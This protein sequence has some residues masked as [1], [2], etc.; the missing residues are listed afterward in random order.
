M[1]EY[2]TYNNKAYRFM[3]FDGFEN[4]L[5]FKKLRFARADQFND[6]LDNSPF[7]MPVEWDEF[8]KKGDEFVKG[9]SKTI[10]SSYFK[11]MYICCFS[12]EYAS[13][14]SYLMWSH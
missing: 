2:N 11:S 14:E 3:T 1:D 8:L 4:T 10:F 7:L 12:K 9:K 6:P 13:H 5:K